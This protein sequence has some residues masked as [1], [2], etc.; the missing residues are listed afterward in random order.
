MF[1]GCLQTSQRSAFDCTPYPSS[2]SSSSLP[3]ARSNK[4][5]GI[6]KLESKEVLKQRSCQA[7]V[8]LLVSQ[9]DDS[10]SYSAFDAALNQVIVLGDL[11]NTAD[12]AAAEQ[13]AA[14]SWDRIHQLQKWPLVRLF[15]MAVHFG[16][17]TPDRVAAWKDRLLASGGLQQLTPNQ[18]ADLIEV[19]LP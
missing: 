14:Y 15:K 11:N 19:S 18:A 16:R 9:P 6:P 3:A 13:L 1:S 7:V 2:I 12:C 4:T 8:D 10:F 5:A 17:A